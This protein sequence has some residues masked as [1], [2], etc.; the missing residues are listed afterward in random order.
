MLLFLHVGKCGGTTVR[1]IFHAQKWA[2]T[3][4]SMTQRFEG[5]K[6]NRMLNAVRIMLGKNLTRIFVEWHL[7]T[8]FSAIDDL[9][10]FVRVMR[11]DVDFRAIT[12]LRAAE[13][14]VSANGAYF[15]PGVRPDFYLRRF[16]E[17][18][19]FNVL[20]LGR[21]FEVELARRVMRNRARDGEALPPTDLSR[22][23]SWRTRPKFLCTTGLCDVPE[24]PVVAAALPPI[25]ASLECAVRAPLCDEF[26]QDVA[27]GS[28]RDHKGHAAVQQ[29]HVAAAH[30]MVEELARRERIIDAFGCAPL[31]ERAL[32]V[33]RQLDALMF[34]EDP[35]TFQ[36]LQRV[37]RWT[38]ESGVE[39]P[40]RRDPAD[41][42][43]YITHKS[44]ATARSIRVAYEAK[45]ITARAAEM[46]SCSMKVHA[47]LKR[48][49]G[50]TFMYQPD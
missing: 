14:I 21:P 28:W 42:T 13:G 10:T 2:A 20:N 30:E 48:R 34:L 1:G 11:P 50:T 18:L 3:Y 39:L 40:L 7:G 41:T 27:H 16:R 17:F 29:R 6:A 45:D 31:V 8:N 47:E 9:R 38:V 26:A 44:A 23:A 12:I 35:R 46:N 22:N 37:A 33:L 25:N 15:D 32:Q 24:D 4:W 49:Y 43:Q 19:L 36:T 5:W